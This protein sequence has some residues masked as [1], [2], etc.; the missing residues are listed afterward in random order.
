[1]STSV[2]LYSDESLSDAVPHL[3]SF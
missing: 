2:A 1:M 3:G